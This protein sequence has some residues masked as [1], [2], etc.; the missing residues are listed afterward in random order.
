MQY[1]LT[2][3]YRRKHDSSDFPVDFAQSAIMCVKNT[4]YTDC[5]GEQASF[6]NANS[7]LKSHL[8]LEKQEQIFGSF[9]EVNHSSSSCLYGTRDYML[10]FVKGFFFQAFFKIIN[11]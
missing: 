4:S 2:V 7:F 5:G 1:T 9:K 11:H 3:T 6:T 8:C 10:C